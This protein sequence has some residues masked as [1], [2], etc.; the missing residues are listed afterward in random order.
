MVAIT[1]FKSRRPAGRAALPPNIR[2]FQSE[3]AGGG[4][5]VPLYRGGGGSDCD[6]VTRNLT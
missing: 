1:S 6:D 4:A 5:A 2:S 3:C